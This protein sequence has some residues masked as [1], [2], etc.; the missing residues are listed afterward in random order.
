MAN[1]NLVFTISWQGAAKARLH[2]VIDNGT[3]VKTE[4]D[5][6]EGHSPITCEYA[7]A[8]AAV[9]VVEWSLWFPGA[10][11]KQLAAKVAIN[12]DPPVTLDAEDGEAK[13]KWAG[14]GA[15]P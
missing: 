12:G 4:A 13:H 9:H 3:V 14:R 8:S 10:T 1:D 5:G 11:V 7:A 15:A 2:Y 6:L